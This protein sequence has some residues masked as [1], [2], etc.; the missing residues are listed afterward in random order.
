MDE[1]FATIGKLYL[2][3]LQSQK[4]IEG[5]QKQIESRD[6]DIANLQT[7]IITQENKM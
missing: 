4:I 2:D 7:A 1:I 3:L 5:L 6:K